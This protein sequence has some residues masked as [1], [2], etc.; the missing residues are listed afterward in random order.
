[1]DWTAIGRWLVLAGALLAGMGGLLWL[2]GKSGMPI[3]HLPGDI[4]LGGQR[5][6]FY[7]PL[8]TCLLVSVLLT[9][10]VNVILRI[11]R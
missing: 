2:A 7:F 10:V 1:M 3:G 11:F 8:G 6:S 5:W 9:I 4:R